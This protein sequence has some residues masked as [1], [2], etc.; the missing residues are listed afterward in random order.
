[1]DVIER[2]DREVNEHIERTHFYTDPLTPERAKMLVKQHRLNTRQRNS[3]LKLMV[4]TNTPDWDTRMK[5]IASSSQEV[6]ADHEFGGGKAHWEVLQELGVTIGLSLAEIEQ[7]QPTTTTRIC[8]LAWEAL[9]RNRHWLEGLIANTCAERVNCPGYGTGEMQR[10]GF[11]G[12]ANR[13]WRETFGLSEEQVQ[14]WHMHSEADVAHSNLGWQTVARD[15]E[16]LHMVDD[17]V[18]ACRINLA[19]WERYWNGIGDAGDAVAAG[20]T[21]GLYL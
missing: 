10:V 4:A 14:F 16:R 2:L 20:R 5:I 18:A 13:V 15:A 1:M 19:V 12:I 9:M 17:V 3:V 21:K 11:G 8:W 6:I 7:A